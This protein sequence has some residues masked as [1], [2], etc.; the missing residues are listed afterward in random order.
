VKLDFLKPF[1]AHNV[2]EFTL[3]P[4]GDSTN[5]TWTMDGPAPYISKLM[6]V[7]MSMD[8]M[9]GKDFEAGL[10]NMKTAAEK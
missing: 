7:F 10:A 6:T 4:K 2:A 8:S 1:E 9:I 3:E 5:V